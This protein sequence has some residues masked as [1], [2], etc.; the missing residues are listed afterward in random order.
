MS[1]QL[2]EAIY[3]EFS[4]FE[5]PPHSTNYK[6]C[7]ECADYDELLKSVARENLSV[8]E[9][10]TVCWG[11]V[12]FLLPEAMAYYL[13]RLMELAILGVRNKENASF[14]SQFLNQI[15]TYTPNEPQFA[16]LNK[17]HIE[18]MHECLI[19]IN[20]NHREEIED[21]CCEDWVEEAIIKWHT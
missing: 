15:G 19:F 2:I 4:C 7:P 9:I 16:L 8:E 14:I 18:L 21:E 11:P 1:Q 10:G 17:S 20:A 12:A 5:K 3:A 6:H 13:P